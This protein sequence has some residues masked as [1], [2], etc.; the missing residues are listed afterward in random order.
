MWQDE[1]LVDKYNQELKKIA[2]FFN[3]YL[4]ILSEP[5]TKE[6]VT[7][8]EFLS[9]KRSILEKLLPIDKLTYFDRFIDYEGTSYQ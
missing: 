8:K 2:L 1:K 4:L 5:E 7:F 9:K 3:N 6:Y